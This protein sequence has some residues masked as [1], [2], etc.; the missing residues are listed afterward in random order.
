[1]S[2]IIVKNLPKS[3]SDERLRELFSSRGEI[4][5]VKLA[6][7]ATGTFRR[8]A[9][10]GFKTS[11]QAEAAVKYF[12]KAF[13]DTCRMGVSIDQICMSFVLF[14]SRFQVELAKGIGDESI[15]RPWSRYSKGSSRFERRH[16]TSEARK[17]GMTLAE[18]EEKVKA[19]EK[20]KVLYTVEFSDSPRNRYLFLDGVCLESQI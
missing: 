17:A 15:A 6:K 1:M 9:F 8:F 20:A 10:V 16:K 13:M 19:E 14:W 18:Y 3:A 4:T 12:N 7:T 5:D 11:E 2:R